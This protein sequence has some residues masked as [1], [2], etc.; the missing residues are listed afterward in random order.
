MFADTPVMVLGNILFALYLLAGL[1]VYF[2]LARQIRAHHATPPPL[3]LNLTRTIGLPE[4]VLALV[5]VT[6]LLLN[7]VA[8]VSRTSTRDLD[9]NDLIANLFLS[10]AVVLF[11][12]TF[13]KVRGFNLESLGGFS[14]ITFKRA[15]STGV[16][17]LFFTYPLLALAEAVVQ[18]VFG[19][20]SSKQQIIDLFTE[21]QTLQ[22]RIMVI[23]L[24]V[25]V[26]P[27]AE[28]F[29]FRFFLYGVLKRY[30]G[31]TAALLLNAGLFA[32]VHTHL[33]SFAP[34]FVL[35]VCFTL[36]Y[37]WSGSILVSMTMHALFN[38][39]QLTVLAFPQLV[40][41]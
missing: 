4:A 22:Q 35:A 27:V 39:V 38:S 16:I 15:A 18:N 25:I 33:P 31:V 36:A 10:A 40:R 24:A 11:I 19:T 13:L 41:Q 12:A 6:F 28:E 5:L 30:L 34:L 9:T 29:I 7:V 8:A 14:R 26:A 37:E 20:G 3:D 23:V 17:L 1:F 21:S 2:S 32:A